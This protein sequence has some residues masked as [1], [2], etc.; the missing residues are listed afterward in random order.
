MVALVGILAMS[1]VIQ[2]P[3]YAFAVLHPAWLDLVVTF[4]FVLVFTVVGTHMFVRA[5]RNR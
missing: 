2:K 3:E 4:G 5:D 1:F